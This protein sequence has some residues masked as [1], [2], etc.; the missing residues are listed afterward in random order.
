MNTLIMVLICLVAFAVVAYDLLWICNRFFPEFP[1]ARWICGAI[2][3]IVA[4]VFLWQQFPPLS[5]HR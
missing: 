4:L 2:F 3:L 5:L 1:P